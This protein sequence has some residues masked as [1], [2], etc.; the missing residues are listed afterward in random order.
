MFA[1][2]A[3]RERGAS[4]IE[5]GV[6]AN[7]ID[8]LSVVLDEVGYYGADFDGCDADGWLWKA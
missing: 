4:G 5:Q 2:A 7:W 6:Y 3:L 8:V 1:N